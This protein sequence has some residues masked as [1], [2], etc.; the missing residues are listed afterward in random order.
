MINFKR[1]RSW[2]KPFSER[3]AKRVRR[4]PTNDLTIWADQTIYELGRILSIY[5]RNNTP[6]ASKELVTAAE[7]L[8]AVAEEIDRRTNTSLRT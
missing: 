3:I 7:A 2:D 5:E 4:I 8:H 6:E 1:K